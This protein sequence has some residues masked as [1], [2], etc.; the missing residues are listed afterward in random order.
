MELLYA[1]VKALKYMS[2]EN[3]AEQE[4]TFYLKSNLLLENIV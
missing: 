4:A 2:T 1:E 3:R